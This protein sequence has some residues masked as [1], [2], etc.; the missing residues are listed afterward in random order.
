MAMVRS[1]ITNMVLI[2][3]MKRSVSSGTTG[4]RQPIL[5]SN[6]TEEIP[7][8]HKT[9]QRTQEEVKKMS[10]LE[11]LGAKEVKKQALS[12]IKFFSYPNN[13]AH[14]HNMRGGS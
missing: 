11:A 2:D 4:A 14:Q 13:K 5:V 6:N 10:K 3:R 1:V 8:R 7:V 12:Q 9:T